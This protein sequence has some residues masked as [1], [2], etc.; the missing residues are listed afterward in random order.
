MEFRCPFEPHGDITEFWGHTRN[1]WRNSDAAWTIFPY[2][3]DMLAILQG[4]CGMGF[5][6]PRQLWIIEQDQGVD[7][8]DETDPISSIEYKCMALHI[9]RVYS[10]WTYPNFIT[11]Q[12]SL[13]I[14]GYPVQA[15][16]GWTGGYT[17]PLIEISTYPPWLAGVPA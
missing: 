5:K 1:A 6:R 8:L 3:D 4:C 14:G 9:P 10:Y 17:P 12:Y 13:L 16:G 11:D 2:Y 7:P 15:N